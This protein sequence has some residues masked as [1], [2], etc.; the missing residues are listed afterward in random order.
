MFAKVMQLVVEVLSAGS[1]LWKFEQ[2]T[3]TS[4]VAEEFAMNLCLQSRFDNAKSMNFIK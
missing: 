3:G 1:D 4:I 2:F